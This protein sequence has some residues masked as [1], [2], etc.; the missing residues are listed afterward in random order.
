MIFKKNNGDIKLKVGELTS[1]EE[2]GK[3]IARMDSNVMKELGVRE[4]DVIEIEGTRVTGAIAVRPY[5]EDIG[6]EVVRMD[7]LV[8]KN[9]GTSVGELVKIRKADVKEA[10]SVVLAPAQKGI[11]IFMNPNILRQK[12]LM[13]PACKGDIVVPSSVID[14]RAEYDPFED[15]FKQFGINI[16]I[17]GPGSFGSFGTEIKMIVT[18]VVPEGMVR[19]GEETEVI[20]KEDAVEKMR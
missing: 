17:M 6:L 20:L 16:D 11:R 7:G 14:S 9:A 5:P 12:L 2:Y 1:R 15:I 18:K 13:R 10:K 8:R 4:G 19:V 3:G